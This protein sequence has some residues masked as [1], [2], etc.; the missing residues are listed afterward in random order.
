MCGF[1]DRIKSLEGKNGVLSVSVVHCFP[2]GEVSDIGAKILVVTDDR[3]DEGVKLAETLGHE[4]YRLR[5][6]TMPTFLSVEQ[7]LDHARARG[8]GPYVIADPCDNAG[9]GAPSDNTTI[10]RALIERKVEDAALGL[11]CDPVAGGV[12]FAGWGCVGRS[13]WM[14]GP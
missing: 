6:S 5:G 2:Y 14:R 7:A 9:G 12:S 13:Q 4:L 8:G 10:L 1:G 3:P 11:L